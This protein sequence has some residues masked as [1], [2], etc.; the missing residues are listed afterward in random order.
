MKHIPTLL[1]AFTVMLS[2]PACAKVNDAAFGQRVRAYLLAHPEVLEEMVAKLDEK[3][4]AQAAEAHKASQASLSKF[5]AQLERD[6][7]DLVANPGG[8]VTVVQFADYKCG[9]CKLAAPEVLA[10]IAKNPDIRVVFKEFPI[11]HGVSDTAAKIALVPAVKAKGVKLYG[12]WMAEK[13][14]DDDGIDRHL[15]AAGLDP[16]QVR[17]DAE[18]PEIAAQLADTHKLAVALNLQGTPAY[19]IGDVLVPGADMDAIKKAIERARTS[20]LKTIGDQRITA[21]A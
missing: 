7:R 8:S 16:V 21:G 12:E 18:S 5:R 14:L 4:Q 2:L 3:K 17:K 10:L 15:R 11:F 19:V 9:Y 6:P 20:N 13:A 1:A